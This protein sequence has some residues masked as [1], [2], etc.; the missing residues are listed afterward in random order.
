MSRAERIMHLTSF[1]ILV[2]QNPLLK[3][4]QINCIV[5][6]KCFFGLV[7]NKEK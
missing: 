1:S 7:N 4:K 5:N 6:S 3:G 2:K